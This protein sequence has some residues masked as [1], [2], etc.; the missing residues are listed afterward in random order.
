MNGSSPWPEL[1]ADE[2]LSYETRTQR[3]SEARR[4]TL[5]TM[6][7]QGFAGV[8]RW[9]RQSQVSA[10]NKGWTIYSVITD[11]D[12]FDEFVLLCFKAAAG[13]ERL[14][15]RLCLQKTLWHPDAAV[16]RYYLVQAEQVC[17]RIE[18]LH[19]LSV[20]AVSRGN[21]AAVGAPQRQAKRCPAIVLGKGFTPAGPSK[22]QMKTMSSL[23]NS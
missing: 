17:T 12:L 6:H 20:S 23:T 21:M 15:S 18:R 9:I 7:T 1:A 11:A 14:H 16:R 19:P 5:R 2:S 13:D 8:R 22:I 4:A 3:I 10:P